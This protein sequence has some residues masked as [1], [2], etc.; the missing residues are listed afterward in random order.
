MSK[1]D[2]IQVVIASL[3]LFVICIGFTLV[4]VELYKDGYMSM[5]FVI[6]FNTIINFVVALSIRKYIK[7]LK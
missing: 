6:V 5:Q 4:G 7:N 1:K 2:K 3:I